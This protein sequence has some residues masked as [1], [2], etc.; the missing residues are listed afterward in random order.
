MSI[1]PTAIIHP[2]AKVDHSVKIGAFTVIHE[3]VVIGAG[4]EIGGHCEIGIPTPVGDGTPLRIGKGSTIRS[5]SIFYESSSFGDKLTT[6]HRVTVRELTRAGCSFQIG[7][8][9]DIQGHCKI[10]DYVKFHS[11]VHVGQ[12]TTI[13]NYVWVFPYV[14]FT[15]D[16]HP[17]SEVMQGVTVKSYA[18]IATM[19][20]ILPG[21]TIG[22]GALIGACSAV[23]KDVADHRI[24]VGNPATDR[25][26]TSR[27][28]LQDGTNRS[29]YPWKQHFHRGYP[30]DVVA[31]WLS[32]AT[33]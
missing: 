11:N 26:E 33:R 32:A 22:E 16:P 31:E 18:A 20:T 13:E 10:G 3:N 8:L 29:A 2:N 17:P 30:E 19:S 6:G 5:H 12:H 23:T 7:T 27:I 14:V 21:V 9:G 1:H 25:G 15:N 4:T 24:A 28:K